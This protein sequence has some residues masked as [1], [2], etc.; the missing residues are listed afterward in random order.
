[1]PRLKALLA[2]SWAFLAAPLVLATFMGM[3]AFATK[4]VA[5]TGLHVHPI[6]SGGAVARTIPHGF[7]QTVI[8][9]PVFDGL[10]GPRSHGFVQ[11]EWQP[12]DANLPELIHEAIDF[13]ADGT[14]EFEVRFDTRTNSARITP[15]DPCVLSLGEALALGPARMVRVN[16]KAR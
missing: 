10:I 4:L 7:Y 6:Y 1:M 12:K 14:S 8:H 16:L 15:L 2:Y 9:E 5:V 3:D 11:V 13:D